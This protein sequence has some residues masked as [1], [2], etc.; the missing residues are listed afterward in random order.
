MSVPLNGS[1]T[2]EDTFAMLGAMALG[3]LDASEEKA[4][5]AHVESCAECSAELEALTRV[6]AAL[7]EAPEGG[8]M[9]P[10][11]SRAIRAALV[12]RAEAGRMGATGNFWKPAAIAASLLVAALGAGY[13]RELTETRELSRAVA[14]RS[15]FI[16]SIAAVV[17]QK[18][19]QIAAMTGP[20]VSIVELSS[21]AV[22][23]PSA[24][25]FWD[26]A[27]NRWTMYAHGLAALQPGRAYE[28]WLVTAE[29]KIPAGTFKPLP[30]GSARFTATY[31]LDPSALMAIAVTEEPEA[32][33]PAPTGEIVLLGTASAPR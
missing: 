23:A 13:Y 29:A 7:P 2:H 16:D 28:L 12:E 3:A 22:Q 17:R 4:L 25:M 15:A 24:R 11:R 21:S 19:E 18:D 6:V 33:V 14:A 26:R 1:F 30:D 31:E 32:G 5:L 10:D 20:D 27:T 9:A 8:E